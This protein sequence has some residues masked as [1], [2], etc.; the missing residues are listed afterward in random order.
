MDKTKLTQFRMSIYEE[1]A[2]EFNQNK[3]RHSLLHGID[4]QLNQCGRD[5]DIMILHESKNKVLEIIIKVLKNQSIKYKIIKNLWAYWIIGYKEINNEIFDIEIDI[6]WSIIYWGYELTDKNLLS[7]NKIKKNEFF[8][9]D[10][11]SFAKLFLILFFSKNYKY[12]DDNR[13]YEISK[14]CEELLNKS[15][16]I[17]NFDNDL[18]KDIIKYG[19]KLDI[20]KLDQIRE[21][22]KLRSFFIQNPVKYFKNVLK[23]LVWKIQ[24]KIFFHKLPYFSLSGPDGVGKST[25]LK[26]IDEVLKSSIFTKVAIKHW[27]PNLL[28]N[29]SNSLRFKLNNIKKVQITKNIQPRKNAGKFGFLRILYYSLDFFLGYYFIDIRERGAL[30]LLIY[31][32]HFIDMI[33]HPERFGINSIYRIFL[34]LFLYIIPLPSYMLLLVDNPLNIIHR[35]NELIIEEIEAQLKLMQRLI[36]FKKNIILVNVKDIEKTTTKILK[37]IYEKTINE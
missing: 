28:P 32:R 11:N 23:F 14:Y 37:I 25:Y 34:I 26:K 5:I 36:K 30:N 9:D 21:K 29:I 33:I 35:K 22:L 2:V 13:K 24:E 4:Y 1:L 17:K 6:L 20:Q 15:Y 12:L 18:Y 10:F 8:K 3:I 27:R 16:S 19:A 31:D 7:Y